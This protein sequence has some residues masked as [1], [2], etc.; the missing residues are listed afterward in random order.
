[1]SQGPVELCGKRKSARRL[2]S[3]IGS[4][5]WA[6]SI[7]VAPIALAIALIGVIIAASTGEIRLPTAVTSLIPESAK[8]L[9]ERA[10]DIVPLELPQVVDEG[11][12]RAAR[13][14]AEGA[15]EGFTMGSSEDVVRAVQGPPTRILASTWYYGESEVYFAGGRVVG[16]KDS[17]KNPLKIR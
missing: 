3:L 9:F 12:K 6:S 17:S 11:A 14:R 7:V 10:R 5:G 13:K 1:M 16:W 4:F 2:Q 8:E 15:A